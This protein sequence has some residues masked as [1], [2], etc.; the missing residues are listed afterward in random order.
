MK[1]KRKKKEKKRNG[2][3]KILVPTFTLGIQNVKILYLILFELMIF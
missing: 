2:D 3:K 1:E